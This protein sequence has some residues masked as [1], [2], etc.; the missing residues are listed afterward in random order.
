MC[1]SVCVLVCGTSGKECSQ[2]SFCS[3][4]VGGGGDL[5]KLSAEFRH[6]LKMQSPNCEMPLR[7]AVILSV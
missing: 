7:L 2:L 4:Y 1:V 5:K 6:L 3:M